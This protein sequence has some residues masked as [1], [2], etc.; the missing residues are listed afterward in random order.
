MSRSF[1][2]ASASPARLAL[3]KTIGFTPS[4]IAPQNIVE[5]PFPKERAKDF[6]V[7]MAKEKLESAINAFPDD[8]IVSAD[9]IVA[10]GR[11]IIQKATSPEEQ[12][13]FM[14]LL[15]GRRHKVY[16]AL[17]IFV[18]QDHSIRE[19]LEVTQVQFKRLSLQE[20]DAYVASNTWRG[21]A[22]YEQNG[23]CLSFFK[24]ITG[25]NTC[26]MGLPVMDVKNLLESAGV[27]SSW[28]PPL[29]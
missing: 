9:T 22:G 23:L 15:S 11:R 4:C 21:C 28:Y 3:L 25:T 13:S 19:R 16:T 5:V 2:L 24:R 27:R 29:A 7:R 1:I 6:V 20:I 18:P 10:C 14:Q 26:I 12:R 17:A 8:V